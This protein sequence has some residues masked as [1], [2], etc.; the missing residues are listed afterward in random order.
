M[1]TIY[2]HLIEDEDTTAFIGERMSFL[3]NDSECS[4]GENRY[5][6][7]DSI[8]VTNKHMKIYSALLVVKEM[9]ITN[10]AVNP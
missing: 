4:P 8:H 6:T 10:T 9:P 5:F 2:G 3:I 7:K 1:L